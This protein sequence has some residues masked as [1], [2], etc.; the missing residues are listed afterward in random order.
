MR[1]LLHASGSL[2]AV[3]IKSAMVRSLCSREWL[4]LVARVM[5]LLGPNGAGK[6]TTVEILEGYRKRD[7]GEVQVLGTDPETNERSFKER[8]GIVLQGTSVDPFFTV[9]EVIELYGGYYPNPLP[10]DEG[11]EIVGL[12]GK[13][14]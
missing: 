7:A 13:A 2:G 6:T 11:I 10:V 4:R 9:R 3:C 5:A 14:H 8:I 1:S 12:T